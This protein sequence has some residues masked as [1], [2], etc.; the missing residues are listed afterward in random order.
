MH[1]TGAR[2]KEGRHSDTV[3]DNAIGEISEE[4]I[5]RIRALLR[6]LPPSIT[7]WIFTMH[8]PLVRQKSDLA[9]PFHLSDLRHPIAWKDT[10]YESDWFLAVFLRNDPSESRKFLDVVS[11]ELNR[12]PDAS[13]GDWPCGRR[14]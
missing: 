4:Q 5:N 3:G 12:R 7:Q 11:E 9:F 13:A 8:H 1:Q 14:G 10:L 2:E 6:E